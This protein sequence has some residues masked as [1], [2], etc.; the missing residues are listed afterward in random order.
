VRGLYAIAD[1]DFLAQRRVPPL[2]FVDALLPAGPA[3]IQLR[4]K[5]LGARET[6]A[7]LKAM[8]ARCAPLGIP[9]FAN[10]RPD[11]AVLAEC[12][13]VH[14]GQTDLAITDA[15]RLAPGLAI[16]I[17]THRLEEVDWALPHRP[18]Y[19]AFGPIFATGSKADAE[20]VVGL[21]ALAEAARRCR[22]AGVPLVAIG[23]LTPERAASVAEYA[24]AGAMISALL[25]AAGLAEVTAHAARLHALLGGDTSSSLTGGAAAR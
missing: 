1:V 17:S 18:T 13:G 25:P 2:A 9:V 11:L 23:G 15:R 24:D 19:V 4:A 16:G 8:R 12:A 14:L 20:A 10:D 21:P 3:A 7:L 5:S 22:S 6:L